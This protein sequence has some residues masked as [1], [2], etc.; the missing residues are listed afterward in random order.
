M[1]GKEPNEPARKS[2]RAKK[3]AKS[4]KLREDEHEVRQWLERALNLTTYD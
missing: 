2:G 3:E 4:S 1:R